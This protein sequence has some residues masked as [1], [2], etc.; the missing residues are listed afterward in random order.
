MENEQIKKVN[1]LYIFTYIFI[2]IAV[3]ALC[4]IISELFFPK[5]NMAAIL[6]M[7]PVII[8]VIWW[9]FGGKIIFKQKQKK[10]EEEL[11][12][13]GF[14]RNQTFYA[15][16]STV[17]VDTE[18]GKIAII[19]YWNPFQ[20]YILP[21][22]RITKVWVDDGKSGAGIIEGSSRVSFLFN[23]DNVKIRV[24]TF[25]SNQRW[26]MD[27]EYILTGISKADM[28]AEVIETARSKGK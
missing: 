3:S 10:M 5:G 4:F 28:M 27:S 16:G 2:P 11:S 17:V 26:R 21:A 14:N 25:T 22:N 9:I 6:I 1:A 12:Q 23:I 24:N 15:D 20:R 7:G 19:F 13:S 18:N 8:S